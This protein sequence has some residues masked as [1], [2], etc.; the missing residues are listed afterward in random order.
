MDVLLISSL[1]EWIKCIRKVS[2]KHSLFSCWPFSLVSISVAHKDALQLVQALCVNGADLMHFTQSGGPLCLL[3]AIYAKPSPDLNGLLNWSNHTWEFK[4]PLKTYFLNQLLV[5]HNGI[6]HE[7]Y[8]FLPKSKQFQLFYIRTFILGSCC[9][10]HIKCGWG[11][12]GVCLRCQIW[13][14]YWWQEEDV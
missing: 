2:T 4:R 8:S 9:W 3:Q 5:M 13:S 12:W 14:N 7:A 1:L 11:C 6:L 10:H